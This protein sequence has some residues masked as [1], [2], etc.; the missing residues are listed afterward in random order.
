MA[1]DRWQDQKTKIDSIVDLPV[2]LGEEITIGNGINLETQGHFL[3]YG[4]SDFVPTLS[5]YVPWGAR[6]EGDIVLNEVGNYPNQGFG[7]IAHPYK[8]GTGK[9]DA[10]PWRRWDLLEKYPNTI[11]GFEILHNTH[12]APIPTLNLWDRLLE[13]GKKFFAIGNSDAHRSERLGTIPEPGEAFTYTLGFPD[14]TQ[15]LNALR[16]GN[17]IASNGPF[18]TVTIENNAED[19]GPG[20]EVKANVGSNL[21]LNIEWVSNSDYGELEKVEIFDKEGHH[22]TLTKNDFVFDS[23]TQTW[24]AFYNNYTVKGDGYIRLRGETTLGK[25]AYTNPIFISIKG[26]SLDKKYPTPI[27]GE[28]VTLDPF[29]NST[30]DVDGNI[31][32]WKTVYESGGNGDIYVKNLSTGIEEPVTFDLYDQG[33][34][35]VSRNPQGQAIVVWADTRNG[36]WDKV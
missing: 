36:N 24:K 18:I 21:T 31:V 2:L 32:V 20:E 14:E 26:A 23:G 28:F 30:P 10:E 13:Q 25:V 29:N 4:I 1:G 7:Y 19:K 3:A 11:K 9:V 27:G 5:S 17:S 34:P 12:D 22:K 35:S 16:A 33:S 8:F 6:T 15:I